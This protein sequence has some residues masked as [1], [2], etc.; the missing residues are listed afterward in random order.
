MP[1]AINPQRCVNAKWCHTGCI[2]GAKNSLI[3]NY[4]PS[5]ERLGVQLRTNM[6]VESI[7]QSSARPYRYIVTASVMDNAGPNPTQRS[8]VRALYRLPFIDN[9]SGGPDAARTR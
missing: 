3:T 9:P 8:L 4:L 5:A 1:V 7:R 6:Q 2:F